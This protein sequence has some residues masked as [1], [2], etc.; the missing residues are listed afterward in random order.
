M[1]YPCFR[2]RPLHESPLITPRETP[3]VA[4]DGVDKTGCSEENDRPLPFASV[5]L[6]KA[7]LEVIADEVNRAVS[8][9]E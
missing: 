4:P 2:C 6:L 9:T 3:R 7:V 8:S 1:P 5:S